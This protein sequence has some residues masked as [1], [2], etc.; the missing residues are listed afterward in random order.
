MGIKPYS[1]F[2]V[3]KLPD[4]SEIGRNRTSRRVTV[5]WNNGGQSHKY[6]RRLHC[7]PSSRIACASPSLFSSH[8]CRN[9]EVFVSQTSLEPS[10]TSYHLFQQIA[11]AGGLSEVSPQRHFHSRRLIQ[12]DPQ[13]DSYDASDEYFIMRT[14]RDFMGYWCGV[15]T[16]LDLTRSLCIRHCH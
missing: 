16:L 1:K 10:P 9:G 2:H 8:Y 14:I 3:V 5:H 6:S 12:S 7:Q 4:H 13:I 11:D 15:L